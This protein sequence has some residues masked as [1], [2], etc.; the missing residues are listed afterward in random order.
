MHELLISS[1]FDSM[2]VVG[3]ATVLCCLC[4]HMVVLLHGKR[5][6][7]EAKRLQQRQ[8][9]S[10]PPDK[11]SDLTSKQQAPGTKVYW[12]HRLGLSARLVASSA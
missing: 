11:V 3:S 7:A 2:A 10:R 4:P 8:T 12:S 1:F 6:L 5:F 9:E